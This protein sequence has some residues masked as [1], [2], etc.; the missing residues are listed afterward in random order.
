MERAALSRV[1]VR[2][3]EEKGRRWVAGAGHFTC[4]G[5]AS[6]RA[7]S[8]RPITAGAR[9]AGAGGVCSL[10]RRSTADEQWHQAA[11]RRGHGMFGYEDVEGLRRRSTV[12]VV[13]PPAQPP[14]WFPWAFSVFTK[15]VRWAAFRPTPRVQQ[16][17]FP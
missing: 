15:C 1:M 3:E 16:A 10:G 4:G 8:G 14:D 2:E 5:G 6:G 13:L 9:E 17:R 11:P 7:S 12:P